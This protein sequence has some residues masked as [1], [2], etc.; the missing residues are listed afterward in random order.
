M[1]KKNKGKQG[2]ARP[3]GPR[4]VLCLPASS[5]SQ[6]FLTPPPPPLDLSG[7]PYDVGDLQQ[8]LPTDLYQLPPT[9]HT[10]HPEFTSPD[11]N[12]DSVLSANLDYD[13][14]SYPD[15]D[16]DLGSY[17]LEEES[18]TSQE[19]VESERW[20][21]GEDWSLQSEH[22][23]TSVMYHQ[24]QFETVGGTYMGTITSAVLPS[25][26]DQFGAVGGTT[27]GLLSSAGLPETRDQ[28]GTGGGTTLDN[29]TCVAGLPGTTDGRGGH[30]IQHHSS[31]S[32]GLTF[33]P[34]STLA[35][36]PSLSQYHHDSNAAIALPGPAEGAPGDSRKGYK[37]RHSRQFLPEGPEKQSHQRRLNNEASRIR[38]K[39]KTEK[40][41]EL[42]N[43][44]QQLQ[45]S[46]ADLKTRYAQLQLLHQK[47]P[48]LLTKLLGKPPQYR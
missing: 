8:A 16:F 12:I 7:Q 13:L 20:T 10:Q 46:N 23:K 15:L 47:F 30:F 26:S 1:D 33:N 36:T 21:P 32:H 24:D 39:K 43:E 34:S 14:N 45:Q 48:Q 22:S 27:M 9:A 29:V 2:G 41:E 44:L 17:L 37:H 18:N 11:L 6:S 28:F 25:T 35:G 5:P 38:N 31:T 4:E 40:M 19:S 3:K 42:K